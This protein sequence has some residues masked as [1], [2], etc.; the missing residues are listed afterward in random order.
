MHS[1]SICKEC[2]WDKLKMLQGDCRGLKWKQSYN[3]FGTKVLIE[4][5]KKEYNEDL[6]KILYPWIWNNTT[7]N[8]LDC[9]MHYNT[10]KGICCS[11]SK[12]N[13]QNRFEYLPKDFFKD[14]LKSIIMVK[15][16]LE[17]NLTKLIRHLLIL[18]A[19]VVWKDEKA[20]IFPGATGGGKTTLCLGLLQN[21]FQYFS[22]DWALIDP[23]SLK[24]W[25]FPRIMQVREGTLKL[26]P[27]LKR[28][29]EKSPHKF[30][31]C[32]DRGIKIF[33]VKADDILPVRTNIENAKVE[34]IVFLKY[35]PTVKEPILK[36]ISAMEALKQM[37][38]FIENIKL[39]RVRGYLV[40]R[41]VKLVSNSEC[42][43]LT[44]GDIGKT[45]ELVSSL[46]EK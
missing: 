23:D 33:L 8:S 18:H 39:F 19:G 27:K 40:K 14:R 20:M 35:S 43:N 16:D 34:Y 24:V 3:F 31:C 30:L 12:S 1:L 29:I 46:M 10:S 32:E 13:R 9:T 38:F 17:S 22:D 28:L 44:C 26:F 21:G 2:K 41:L 37:L 36:E 15:N 5:D 6:K 42:F 45:T 25:H 11:K 4:F 7:N